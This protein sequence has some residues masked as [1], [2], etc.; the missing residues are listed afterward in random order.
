[1][2]LTN[3]SFQGSVQES[4]TRRLISFPSS[5]QPFHSDV[6]TGRGA[7]RCHENF[8][9][10]SEIEIKFFEL[11]LARLAL[12]DDAVETAEKMPG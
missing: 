1:M 5:G 10:F 2:G 9:H 11:R 6:T 4:W 12:A 8:F 3:P 7:G